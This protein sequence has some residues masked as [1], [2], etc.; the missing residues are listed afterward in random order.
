MMFFGPRAASPPKNTSLRV[1]W[2]VTGFTTGMPH[3]SNSRP[4]SR[5]IQ[6]KEFSWPTATRTSSHSKATSGSPV[7]TR[8]RRPFESPGF[9]SE[10]E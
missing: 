7:G 6:G 1:D 9:F 10:S 4:M 5:S 3:L 2:N 8:L